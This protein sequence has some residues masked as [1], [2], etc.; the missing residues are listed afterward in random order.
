MPVYARFRA[1]NRGL[2]AGDWRLGNR[3]LYV[4]I[5]KTI[6]SFG[7]LFSFLKKPFDAVGKIPNI[8]DVERGGLGGHGERDG[9]GTVPYD[10][11]VNLVL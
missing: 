5:K 7:I 2:G 8:L 6:R 11:I 3:F 1:K 4:K 9:T 10:D